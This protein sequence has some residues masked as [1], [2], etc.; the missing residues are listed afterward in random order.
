MGPGN[1]TTLDAINAKPKISVRLNQYF[2]R[3]YELFLNPRL[4]NS[5]ISSSVVALSQQLCG[6]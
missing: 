4:R 5:T 6:S 2:T 3:F 1:G